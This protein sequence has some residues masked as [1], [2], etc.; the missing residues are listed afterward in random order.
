[1]TTPS[2]RFTYSITTTES[3][4]HGDYADCGFCD[5]YGNAITDRESQLNE[6]DYDIVEQYAEAGDL[7]YFTEKA[8]ELGCYQDNNVTAG[9]R[10][11]YTVDEH[12][13]DYSADARWSYCYHVSGF[14]MKVIRA[15]D[16]AIK[17]GRVTD[18]ERE[19]F[20]YYE[21]VQLSIV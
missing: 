9:N 16:S 8:I 3:A 4:E 14:D 1:M 15:I 20:D 7:E 18:T 6:N 13:K 5:C 12:I 19:I 11:Y 21:S 10:S 17:K 2:I